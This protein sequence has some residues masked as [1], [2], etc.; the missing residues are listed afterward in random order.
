[1]QSF[2]TIQLLTAK[3]CPKGN[4]N[5]CD[6]ACRDTA[7]LLSYSHEGIKSK[8]WPYLMVPQSNC[9]TDSS[10]LHWYDQISV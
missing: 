4:L 10:A 9:I 1:M 8:N 5:M 7:I 3:L 6:N 2:I